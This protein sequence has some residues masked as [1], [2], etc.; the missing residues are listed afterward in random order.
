[1]CPEREYR[2]R[3]SVSR[4]YEIIERDCREESIERSNERE[5]EYLE[6]K[7]IERE[8]RE[9]RE[10]EHRERGRERGRGR[11]SARIERKRESPESLSKDETNM[12]I[13]P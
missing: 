1:M 5:R 8:Y 12:T 11:E 7:S 2:G 9:N 6:R 13:P 10:R 3:V 4:D